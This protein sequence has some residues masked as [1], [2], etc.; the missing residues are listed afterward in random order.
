MTPAASAEVTVLD[1]HARQPLLVLIGSAI[2]WLV[3]S[4]VLAVISSIQLHTPSF[5][6]D[7]A[8]FTHGRVEGMRESA[9]VYGWAANAGLAITLWILGRLG[10]YPL[11]AL[12]WTVIGGVF[13]NLGLLVGLVGIATGDMTS[14]ALLQLPRYVQPLMAVAYASMSIA[15]LLAWSGRRTD[16]TFASQWYGVAGLFLFPWL[17]IAAQVV[18]FWSPLRGSLQSIAVG[19][20]GQGVVL[21][22]LSPLA[23]AAAYYVIP[24][25]T[26]RPLP[27]YEFA[28]LGF[29]TLLVIGGWTAG[30]NLVGSPVPVWIPT[31]ALAAY[32]LLL[33]HFLIVWLNLRGAV[34]A[35]GTSLGFIRF[36]LLSYLAFGVLESLL[37]FRGLSVRTQ[38]TLVTPAVE[39]LAVYGGVS[40][41]F[42]GG[43]YY[44][45]PRLTGAAWASAALTT[46]HRVGVSVGLTL[47]VLALAYGGLTQGAALLDAKVSSA[48][49]L[50]QIRLPLLL[51]TA[52]QVLLLASNLLLLV[53]F[54]RSACAC[55]QN[56]ASPFRQPASMEVNA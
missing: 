54:W 8:M 37:A 38:F 25:V 19:W 12:N 43:L 15:G 1:R 11:R 27:A 50:G 48:T 31:T 51:A 32:S 22:W 3:V 21:L 45:L 26:G 39:L 41:I 52:G 34:S 5:L 16:G 13:W 46:G 33:F 55:S 49:I 28:P 56:S 40:M 24:K 9:F 14:F 29:W 30:R 18:L 20:Y 44:L 10:G 4:G 47:L 17:L 23:L 42:F 36:G 2:S 7:C 53:N 6:Q 35:G